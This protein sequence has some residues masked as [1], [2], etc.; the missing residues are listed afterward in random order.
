MK[1]KQLKYI[2]YFTFSITTAISYDNHEYN[3]ICDWLPY[4]TL[5]SFQVG[6]GYFS[7]VGIRALRD[8]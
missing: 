7:E 8:D 2:K 5:V 6:L 4:P 3:S 1:I